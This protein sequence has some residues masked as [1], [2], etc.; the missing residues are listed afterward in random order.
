M[1]QHDSD[2]EALIE[3]AKAVQHGAFFGKDYGDSLKQLVAAL[4]KLE[5]KPEKVYVLPEWKTFYE[6][7]E[8]QYSSHWD[9]DY[10]TVDINA[11]D[12]NKTPISVNEDRYNLIRELTAINAPEPAQK[13]NMPTWD[14]MPKGCTVYKSTLGDIC[15]DIEGSGYIIRKP[16]F[17]AIR[18]KIMGLS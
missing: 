10:V 15:M 4:A 12:K 2:V 7:Q 8:M 13:W 1:T 18:N 5:P 16:V 3:A 17:E 14:E 6:A 9:G 11:R